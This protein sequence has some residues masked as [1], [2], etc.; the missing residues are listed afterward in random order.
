MSNVQRKQR[1]IWSSSTNVTAVDKRKK[2]SKGKAPK[3]AKRPFRRLDDLHRGRNLPKRAVMGTSSVIL[4][5]PLRQ[6][7]N[8]LT[9]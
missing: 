5:Q 8:T 6:K 3:I 2:N 1:E 4:K 9:C 7:K